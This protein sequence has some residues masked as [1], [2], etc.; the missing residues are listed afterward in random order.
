[1]LSE[2]RH[3]WKILRTATLAIG[4]L[5]FFFALVEI[6]HVFAILRNIN[7]GLGYAFLLLI[8][9][10]L[11]W[12]LTYISLTLKKK[13][14]ALVPFYIEDLTTASQYELK[15]YCRYLIRYFE[16]LTVNRNLSDDDIDL[17]R[18]NIAELERLLKSGQVA[19]ILLERIDEMEKKSI[20]PLLSKLD[21]DAGAEVRSCV[22]DI[23]LG[24][25]LNPLRA[26]DLFVIIYRSAAM[27]LR[28][29]SIYNNRP[30]LSEQ[31]FVLRDVLRV[32]ATINYVNWGQMMA[33]SLTSSLPIVGRASGEIAQ[34]L[35]AG[36]LTSV[37]GHGA[38]DR[39][40]AYRRWDQAIAAQKMSLHVRTFM[41]DILGVLKQDIFP[42][43][44][45]RLLSTI[46]S[47]QIQK[48]FESIAASLEATTDTLIDNLIKKAAK[49]VTRETV[50]AGTSARLRSKEALEQ[51]AGGV[52][53]GTKSVLSGTGK[54]VRF[55][56]RNLVGVYK[57]AGRIKERGNKHE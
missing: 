57:F 22:R 50:R 41:N 29:H 33:G 39:C 10:G 3:W 9:V 56:G 44:G 8:A 55:V 18:Q 26:F 32:V 30:L 53:R 13:R 35:G 54:S 43:V 21:M 27:V 23:M 15:S 25:T 2:L 1:M 52:W 34:G 24:V 16:R 7:P 11:I 17:A 28:I 20:E 45:R 37:A 38:I 6:L 47:E 40:R 42:L 4:L 31:M 19:R 49:T 12:F 46:P 36:L 5:F 14:K 48:T 51:G